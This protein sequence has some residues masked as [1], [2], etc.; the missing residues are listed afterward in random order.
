MSA[1]KYSPA[2]TWLTYFQIYSKTLIELLYCSS[3]PSSS[4]TLIIHYFHSYIEF[5]YTAWYNKTTK[6][7]GYT[8][9]YIPSHPKEITAL[10][11]SIFFFHNVGVQA[12]LSRL[13]KLLH[14]MLNEILQHLIPPH[15]CKF[16]RF[17][18]QV[19]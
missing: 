17:Q 11:F 16:D 18:F 2:A 14:A 13:Q 15:T 5:H 6:I 9:A 3:K 1:A 8:S 10:Q 19:L 12:L 4:H 7:L